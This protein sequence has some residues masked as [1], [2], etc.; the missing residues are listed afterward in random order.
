MAYNRPSNFNRPS[1][2]GG[3][4]FFPPVIKALLISNG[5]I[6]LGT[7]FLGNFRA[8]EFSLEQFFF[9]EFALWPFGVGFGFW[10]LFTYMFMHAS[11]THILFNMLALWM[12]GME[13]EHVWGSRKFF[14]YYLLCGFGGGLANLLI[15]PMFTTV[16][17]TIGASGAV[18][19]ILIAFGMMFPERLIYIYFLLPI[20]AKYFVVMYMAFEIFSVGSIDGIAHFAHLGGALVGFI[21]LLSDGYRFDSLYGRTQSDNVFSKFASTF[22]NAKQRTESARDSTNA[23]IYPINDYNRTADEQQNAQKQIDDILDKISKDGYQSLNEEEKKVL[24]EA[25]KKLN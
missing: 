4:Q 20:K 25:S 10:Q 22:S 19:G 8:G 16:G 6:F 24:F 17:P 5:A 12:F 15:A 23:K 3:F 14:I 11:F 2:F 18:Y 13:L 1:F 21:Y 9:Q 7:M